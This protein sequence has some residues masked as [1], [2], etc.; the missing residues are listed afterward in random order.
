M[1]M[2]IEDSYKMLMIFSFQG[3]LEES[4]SSRDVFILL[5]YFKLYN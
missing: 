4:F 2:Y 3:D 1:A 5:D